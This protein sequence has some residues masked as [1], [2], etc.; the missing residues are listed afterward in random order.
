MKKLITL[1]LTFVLAVTACISLAACGNTN[2]PVVVDGLVLAEEQYG[3]AA[4]K[5]NDALVSKINEALISIAD[6]EMQTIANKYG[7]TSEIAV[8]NDTVNPLAAASD[9]S[10]TN[11]VSRNK[12]VIGYTVFAPI[13]YEVVEDV[14]TKGYDIELA[15]AVFEYLNETYSS[16]IVVEFLEIDWN[17]K[18]TMLEGGSID[19]VW[20]GLTI[21]QERI[22]NMCISVP[23][24]YNKQVAVVLNQNANKYKTIESM[25]DAIVGAEDGSAGE[26]QIQSKNIGKEYVAC[27]SQLQA[28]QQ[29]K[30]KTLDVI[31]IDSVMAN[32]YISMEK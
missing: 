25:K 23:Y 11:L 28:Y 5:G 13:A 31:V 19:L 14:P 21:T 18:E 10:W 4:K 27:D 1:M 3:I 12:V 9:D 26:E 16:N 24:L 22:D 8:K 7:L 15:K 32:Y 20:N 6:D 29:L 30:T 2:K 17:A